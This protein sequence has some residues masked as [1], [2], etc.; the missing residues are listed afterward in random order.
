MAFLGLNPEAIN[1]SILLVNSFRFIKLIAALRFCILLSNLA[2]N[3]IS[4]IS[5]IILLSKS[6]PS[7]VDF[8]LACSVIVFN[9]LSASSSERVAIPFSFLD[10]STNLRVQS[11]AILSSC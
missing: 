6:E 1:P 4:E 9:R 10:A 8:S 2:R 11:L 7:I 3:F 5:S